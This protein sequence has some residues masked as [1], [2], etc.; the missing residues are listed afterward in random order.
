MGYAMERRRIQ[1]VGGSTYSVSLPKDWVRQNKLKEKDEITFEERT[2]RTLLVRPN[3]GLERKAN[4]ISLNLA[5]FSQVIDQVIFSVYYQGIENITIFSKS[6]IGLDDKARIRKAISHMSG[7]EISYED[8]QKI[9]IKVLLDKSKV[10]VNQVLQRIG[11]IMEQSVKNLAGSLNMN[12]IRVNENEINRLYQLTAKTVSLS[13][14]DSK[15]LESSGIEDI[16]LTLSYFLLAKKLENTGDSIKRLA[17]HLDRK[18]QNAESQ[19]EILRFIIERINKS[20]RHVA[21]KKASVF[22]ETPKETIARLEEKAGN[23]KD[24]SVQNHLIEMIRY[25][26]DIEEEAVSISFCN[27]LA[28]GR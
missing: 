5:E 10:N 22:E 18:G 2:D 13:L 19:K 1:L 23:I 7:T 21:S 20:I 17:K 28:T 14:V 27:S 25:L 12:E 6:D 3:A 16:P 11:L 8:K 4:E 26:E 24:A 15:I 9:I